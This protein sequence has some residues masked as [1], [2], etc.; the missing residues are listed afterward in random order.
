MVG[1][2]ASLSLCR[3]LLNVIHI[4]LRWLPD[5]YGWFAIWWVTNQTELY[6]DCINRCIW[7]SL[8]PTIVADWVDFDLLN[9]T[10]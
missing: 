2:Y 6:R 10:V 8:A 7:Q 9:K 4:W 3:A 5:D 1:D